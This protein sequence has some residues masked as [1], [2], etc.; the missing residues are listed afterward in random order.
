[1]SQEWDYIRERIIDEKIEARE[2]NNV[3]LGGARWRVMLPV[4]GT[5]DLLM[6]L[7]A[8]YDWRVERKG[9]RELRG[10]QSW[11]GL[12]RRG[13]LY[14]GY[15]WLPTL[16][17]VLPFL[18]ISPPSGVSTHH[19]GSEQTWLKVRMR[20][21]QWIKGSNCGFW[22]RAE[23]HCAKPR[24]IMI[25]TRVSILLPFGSANS[26]G[27]G[28][29]KAHTMQL[30]NDQEQQE[31]GPLIEIQ[32]TMSNNLNESPKSSTAMDQGSYTRH[33]KADVMKARHLG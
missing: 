19:V 24:S 18:L 22:K 32:N 14:K 5:I 17:D 23:G 11:Y 4:H 29:T 1:M 27:L 7:R 15:V 25:C 3:G 16:V 10:S 2:G 6:V 13:G 20:E 9:T 21:V 12:S 8:E 30:S 33:M 31:L 26:G 28:P